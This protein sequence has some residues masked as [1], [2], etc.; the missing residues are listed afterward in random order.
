MEQQALKE[1]AKE[2]YFSQVTVEFYRDNFLK[3]LDFCT[4][5]D[6]REEG[7]Y[8][9]MCSK[10]GKMQQM[11]SGKDCVIFPRRSSDEIWI[12]NAHYDGCFGWD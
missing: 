4:V 11:P 5:V 9:S 6:K 2:L 12:V 1:L 10:F 7:Y 3:L 8:C